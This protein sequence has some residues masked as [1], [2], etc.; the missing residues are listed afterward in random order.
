MSIICI[1]II[2]SIILL[3]LLIICGMFESK[4]F[5]S[6]SDSDKMESSALF[7]INCKIIPLPKLY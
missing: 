2:S 3:L 1:Q 7:Y 5:Y 6:R 4:L